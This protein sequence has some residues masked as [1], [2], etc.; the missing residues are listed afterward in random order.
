MDL[1]ATIQHLRADK[2]KLDRVIADLEA[3]AH[4]SQPKSPRGRKSMGPE[5]RKEVS[6]RM[7]RYWAGRKKVKA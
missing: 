2:E 3:L 5:E 4:G 7:K 6:E 1:I